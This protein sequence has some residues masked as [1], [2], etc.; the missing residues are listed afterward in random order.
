MSLNG[1]A[2]G[3][4]V[5][6]VWCGEEQAYLHKS[7]HAESSCIRCNKCRFQSGLGTVIEVIGRYEQLLQYAHA[8][9]IVVEGLV[10]ETVRDI[11]RGRKGI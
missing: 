7:V 5:R 4:W 2:K 3:E 6:C 9:R 1:L 8:H 10:K 11:T